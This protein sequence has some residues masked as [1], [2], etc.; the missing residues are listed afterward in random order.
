MTEIETGITIDPNYFR[1]QYRRVIDPWNYAGSSYEG[2]KYAATLAA[3]PRVRYATALEC[4]CSV[5]VFTAMLAERC[6]ALLAIDLSDEVLE[7]AGVRCGGLPH[8]RFANVD[9]SVD[10]PSGARFDLVAFCE[11]GFYFSA[12]DLT[13]IADAIAASLVPGGDLVLV[14]WTPP[15]RGHALSTGRVHALFRAHAA[16]RPV[17]AATAPTYRLEV[18][19]RR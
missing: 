10:F 7:S 16:F 3:L 19:T 11:L 8:V 2:E 9:L 15:V 14:H 4:A 17:H 5:G 12:A 13:R 1:E 18:F 6:D